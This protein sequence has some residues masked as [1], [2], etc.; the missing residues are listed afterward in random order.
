MSSTRVAAR[1][2]RWGHPQFHAFR[3]HM[4]QPAMSAGGLLRSRM[5]P[6]SRQ[7]RR[8]AWPFGAYSLHNVPAVRTISFARILPK[9]A[10]KLVRIPAMF[11]AAT[12]GGLAYLQYQA[13]RE[14][15]TGSLREKLL[16]VRFA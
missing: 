11:G 5:L 1:L 7:H 16:I 3:R 8:R 13:T 12:I 10:L 14:L 4:H 6:P 2:T 9:L 15:I